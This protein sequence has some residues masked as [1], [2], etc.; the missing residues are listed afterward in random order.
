[1]Q[2]VQLSKCTD[3]HQFVLVLQ[4]TITFVLIFYGFRFAFFEVTDMKWFEFRQIVSK[5]VSAIEINKQL[6]FNSGI[7]T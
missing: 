7:L 4:G 3:A 5:F 6:N 1:M 2:V